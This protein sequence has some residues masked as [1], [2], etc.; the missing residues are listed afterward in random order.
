M[1]MRFLFCSPVSY[2]RLGLAAVA[3]AS[4][5]LGGCIIP[6]NI[7]DDPNSSDDDASESASSDAG[8]AETGSM[9]PTTTTTSAGS[10]SATSGVTITVSG[11]VTTE[12]PDPS[13]TVDGGNPT[14][15]PLSEEEALEA[16][17][18]PIV[19]PEPGG[20]LYIEAVECAQGCG[21]QIDTAEIVDLWEY[22]MCLCDALDCGPPVGGTVTTSEPVGTGTDGEPDGCGPF[23]PGAQAF[24]CDC[25]MCSIDV[26]DVDAIWLEN[27]ADLETICA[28]MCGNTGCGLPV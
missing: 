12:S 5:S 24:T 27:D 4:L 1:I 2:S 7:G 21:I 15:G 3:V 8:K 16:C 11:G 9:F 19:E 6:G 14:A 17:G 25:E 18:V 10:V 13:A 26:N 22:G 20:P 23:P 28:C